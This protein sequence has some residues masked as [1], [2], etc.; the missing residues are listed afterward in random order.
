MSPSR[1]TL[2]VCV[3]ARS[4]AAGLDRLLR[5]VDGFADQ[6]VIGVD[7]ASTDGTFDLAAGR[8][9]VA[10][11]F[12]HVGPPVRARMLILE[13][14]RADWVLSLD[15]DEGLDE[16]FEPLLPELLAQAKHSHVWFPRKWLVGTE[17]LEYLHGSPWY[18]DWQLRLF[19]NDRRRVWHPG[20]LHSGYR[21]VGSGRREDRTAIL[22]YEPLVLTPEARTAK[23]AYYRQHGSDGRS[24]TPYRSTAAERRVVRPGVRQA[25]SSTSRPSRRR[26]V[27]DGVAE[28]P[29]AT[30]VPWRAE[31]SASM[32]PTAAAGATACAEVTARNPGPLAWEPASE[33][34]QLH[35]SYHLRSTGGDVRLFD[36]ARFILPH[37]VEPGDTVRFL[38]DWPAPPDPGDFLVEW[39]LVVEGEAWFGAC[40]SETAT[41]RIRVL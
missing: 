1:P 11:R 7:A 9:D 25:A 26:S 16:R 4:T 34:P 29:P 37:T 32:E 28:V 39:D 30:P 14:A 23:I 36:G 41:T 20:V 24:E 31:L 18:P 33:W 22:H 21:V 10:F 19:R 38:I 27:V 3:L 5:E 13:H 35:L 40:G 12:E 15:E 8:A 6:I 2:S 17:P